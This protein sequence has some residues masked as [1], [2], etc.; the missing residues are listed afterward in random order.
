MKNSNIRRFFKILSF[1]TLTI[2]SCNVGNGDSLL[3][4]NFNMIDAAGLYSGEYS[5]D[6]YGEWS[7]AF[8]PDGKVLGSVGESYVYGYADDKGRFSLNSHNGLSIFGLINTENVIGTWDTGKGKIG[9]LRGSKYDDYE[10]D[11][12]VVSSENQSSKVQEVSEDQVSAKGVERFYG[13]YEGQFFFGNNSN[14]VFQL[15][16][17]VKL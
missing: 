7:L 16:R 3:D 10:D 11:Y 5:G 12:V 6:F 17:L 4:P 13:F 1:S 14:G 9:D 15:I 8:Y 2:L